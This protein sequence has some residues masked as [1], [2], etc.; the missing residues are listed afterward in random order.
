MSRPTAAQRG[1][2]ARW[3]CRRK[4]YLASHPICALCPHPAK[5]ADHYPRSRRQLIADG[6]RDPDADAY[7][8]PLCTNC[9]NK[10]TAKHQPGGWAPKGKRRRAPE[11][12]PGMT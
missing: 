12:H 8:R 10:E 4:R 1:Y 7:L 2:D 5:V 11:P 9:H 6:V 3:Q